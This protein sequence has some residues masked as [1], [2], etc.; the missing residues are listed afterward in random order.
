MSWATPPVTLWVTLTLKWEGNGFLSIGL[1]LLQKT[2]MSVTGMSEANEQ[3]S[4]IL[5]TE[6]RHH[7]SD[8]MKP[9]RITWGCVLSTRWHLL[10]KPDG[11]MDTPYGLRPAGEK[12]GLATAFSACGLTNPCFCSFETKPEIGQEHQINA[13]WYHRKMSSC[14]TQWRH[15]HQNFTNRTANN[16]NQ[17]PPLNPCLLAIWS[18][19]RVPFFTLII[20]IWKRVELV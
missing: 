8:W 16:R 5:P 12:H 4:E 18:T 9:N 7:W 2:R 14:R 11:E 20:E 19:A 3:W 13:S 15:Q 6:G 1:G 10:I 17:W